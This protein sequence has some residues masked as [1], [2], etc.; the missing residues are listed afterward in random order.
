[1][2]TTIHVHGHGALSLYPDV[3]EREAQ[4]AER[5]ARLEAL[6]PEQPLLALAFLAG[7]MPEAF[8]AALEAAE[9]SG[10][11]AP[12]PQEEMEPYCRTCKAPVGLFPAHGL[13]YWHYRRGT[14]TD[15]PRSYRADHPLQLGWRY[16]A[17]ALR[18]GL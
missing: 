2:Q 16:L 15:G 3:A 9:P 1:M 8:D 13:E 5:M 10:E 11:G 6:D 18:A 12:A 14:L 17:D 4:A 7:Y